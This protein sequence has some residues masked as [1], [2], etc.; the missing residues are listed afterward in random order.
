MSLTSRLFTLRPPAP[1]DGARIHA[2]A[3]ACPPLEVNT[4]YAYVLLA[5]HFAD[6]C[7]VAEDDSGLLAYATGYRLPRKQ[8]TLFL[9]QI[10]VHPRA[11]GMGLARQLLTHLIERPAATPVRYLEATVAPSNKASQ[12]LFRGLAHACAV[13]CEERPGFEPEHFGDTEHEP[14]ALFC[15]GPF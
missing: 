5:T 2:L 13:R 1:Q 10:G 8:N 11:R 12:R 14:E 9:W 15:V 7:V 4:P 6:S 3:A